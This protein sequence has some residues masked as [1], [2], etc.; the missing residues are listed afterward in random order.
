M[1]KR[2]LTCCL[3]LVLLCAA[4]ATVQAACGCGTECK[5]GPGCAC[6]TPAGLYSGGP[7]SPA[8]ADLAVRKNA[9]ALTDRERL[10]FIDAVRQLKTTYR[11]GEKVSVYDQYVN[12]HRAALASSHI[13]DDPTI[14]PWHRQFL[15]NFERDL[16]SI[17]PNVTIPYWDFAVDR[18]LK[19]S[20]FDAGFMGG[21]GDPKR[22]YVVTTG[23][24]RVGEWTL[25]SGDPLRRAIGELPIAAEPPTAAQ[26]AQALKIP[27]Y[28]VPPFD[29]SSDLSQSFRAYMVGDWPSEF[30]MHT[31]VHWWVGGTLLS[32]AAPDDPL[33]WLFH[34]NLD[35]IWAEW[36]ALHGLQYGPIESMHGAGLFDKMFGLGTTPESVLDHH[37]LGYRYD[38]E[39]ILPAGGVIPEPG[40]WL[41]F[42]IGTLGFIAYL[43]RKKGSDSQRLPT[44]P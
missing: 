22:D 14:L 39:P 31:L 11:P 38:T 34:A 6:A 2:P 28:D 25:A 44:S 41:L 1:I 29:S 10:E 23:A 13:H 21:T 27:F 42:G 20:V 7:L 33:F 43:W 18:T 9:T 36:E 30:A 32:D 5:C 40:S 35:R 3:A 17:N 15:A 26:V 4:G 16:Q 8:T 12:L 24:F 37:L 19:S